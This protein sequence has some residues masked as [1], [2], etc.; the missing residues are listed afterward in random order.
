MDIRYNLPRAQ[1]KLLKELRCQKDLKI[2][3]C[4]KNLGPGLMTVDQYRSMCFRHLRTGPYR[5][6]QLDLELLKPYLRFVVTHFYERVKRFTSSYPEIIM[7]KFDERGL[8]IIF[9]MPKLHKKTKE[10]KPRH[11]TSDSNGIYIMALALASTAV[12]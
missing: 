8:N 3:M 2:V 4:D 9:G 7:D 6:V 10:V 12:C 11:I 1:R 5:Q